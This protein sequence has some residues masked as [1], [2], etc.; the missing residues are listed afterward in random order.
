MVIPVFLFF[1][2]ISF[3]FL[4]NKRV[5]T[6]KQWNQILL[7]SG[8]LLTIMA[9]FRPDNMPDKPNY[10]SFFLNDF[11][12]ERFEIG[13]V[14]ISEVIR[15]INNDLIF[16]FFFFA[17][18]S[19]YL[20]LWAI[21]RITSLVWGAL[22]I[23]IAN[24]FILHDMIQMRCAIASGFLLHAVFYI[25]KRNLKGF[26][27][28]SFIA[29]FFH[30]SA[31]IIFPLWF[32]NVEKINRFF[33]FALILSSYILAG[34]ISILNYVNYIPIDG[35]QNLVNMYERTVGNDV[36][37]YNAIQLSRVFIC[38]WFLVN[39]KSVYL[40]N[41]ISILLVKIYA[42]SISA[43]PLFSSVPVVAFRV[44]ELYQVVEIVLIPMLIYSIPRIETLLRVWVICIG[45]CFLWMNIYFNEF[46]I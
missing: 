46:L 28:T 40:N 33:Y 14:V 13:F 17:A 21:K 16:F 7:F 36:N 43:L 19:I 11:E 26:L 31:I 3:L 35:I 39:M 29:F 45:L 24:I 25:W 9:T 18:F 42:I 41:S 37:I 23:Y 15:K 12:V 5:P 2:I 1:V 34:H 8:I 22:L 27:I 32:L 6:G 10:I 30:Y 20:K 44:S 4:L 38:V